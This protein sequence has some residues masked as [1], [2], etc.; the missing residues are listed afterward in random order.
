LG[1]I[2]AK[3]A[4]VM[5]T[6]QK[7][8]LVAAGI[9]KGSYVAVTGEK[10]VW[11]QV[12]TASGVSGWI[13]KDAVKLENYN[14]VQRTPGSA[15]GAV[16]TGGSG[17]GNGSVLKEAGHFLGVPY[18]WGGASIRATDCSG[19]LQQVFRE[20]GVKL[21]RTEREQAQVGKKVDLENLRPGDRLY[22]NTKGRAVDHCGIYIGS[23]LFV[24]ASGAKG[25]VVV[26]ALSTPKYANSLVVARR[27]G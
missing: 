17:A 3:N 19:Y 14:V 21:P 8:Q 7:K 4:Q 1:K 5:F 18:K 11:Y 6:N 2:I 16:T 26:D 27:D 12:L 22:F 13:N 25:A 9:A 15:A 24:H 23:D 10:Q 20:M